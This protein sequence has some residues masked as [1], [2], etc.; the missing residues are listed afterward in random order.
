MLST[1]EGANCQKLR[2]AEEMWAFFAEF[3]KIFYDAIPC[4]WLDIDKDVEPHNFQ[5]FM[6]MANLSHTLPLRRLFESLELLTE[7]GIAKNV[8]ALFFGRE[9]EHK[10]PHAI[11]RC[12][13]FKGFDKVH[14][15]DDKTFGGLLYQQYLNA[16]SWIES[17][18]EVEYIIKG[19]GPRE[20]IWEIPLDVFKES[21]RNAICHRDLYEEGGTIMMEVYDD[22]VETSNPGGLLPVV[23]AE[24][25]HKSMSRNP[26]IF[27]LFTRM[28]VVEKVW[29]GIP[30]MR[31]LMKEAGLPEPKFDTQGFFTV[32][33]TQRVKTNS[34]TDGTL[35]GTEQL[36]F[37]CIKA[38]LGTLIQQTNKSVRTIRRI[39]KRLIDCEIIEYKGSKKTGDY[40]ILNSYND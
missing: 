33:F 35:N 5:I 19:T 20:E 36:V 34:S 22:R 31:G 13:R 27:G 30:R 15:I 18:L 29:S 40:Y 9:P 7:E 26:L 1:L 28:Q 3:A 2:S 37:D 8:T 11:I 21:I 16:L 39:V 32:T 12:L 10:F 24:F 25:G 17:K 4:R 14:I 6:E 38:T 23:A